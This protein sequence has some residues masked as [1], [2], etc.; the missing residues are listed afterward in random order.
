M[1][2]WEKT[3][4]IQ[5]EK[6]PPSNLLDLTFDAYLDQHMS[7]QNK[8]V[9]DILKKIGN[10]DLV[11]LYKTALFCVFH[12]EVPF[13]QMLCS[14]CIRELFNEFT[15][16]NKKMQEKMKEALYSDLMSL[17]RIRDSQ[18]SLQKVRSS[19]SID[20]DNLYNEPLKVTHYLTEHRPS[21]SQDEVVS[22][23]IKTLNAKETLENTR[24][25]NKAHPIIIAET[26]FIDAINKIEQFILELEKPLLEEKEILDEILQRAKIQKAPTAGDIKALKNIFSLELISYFFDKLYNHKWYDKLFTNKLLTPKQQELNSGQ[27]FFFWPA[28][29]YLQH[30]VERKETAIAELINVIPL[31]KYHQLDYAILNGILQLALKFTQKENVL[32]VY[33]KLVEVLNNGCT[34]PSYFGADIWIQFLQKLQEMKCSTE[35]FNLLEALLT[36][37]IIPAQTFTDTQKEYHP[38]PRFQNDHGTGENH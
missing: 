15:R 26:E 12:T 4:A 1:N 33:N 32:T 20:M 10:E 35:M 7:N 2:F 27:K 14:H 13:R 28:L 38:I 9:I 18:L 24:H 17:Q 3:M 30:I 19:I 8:H 36:L 16:R 37:R 23:V 34:I 25:I 6:T 5:E 22:R 31:I 21:L 11:N 29:F